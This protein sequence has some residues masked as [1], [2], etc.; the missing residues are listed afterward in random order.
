MSRRTGGPRADTKNV[1]KSVYERLMPG[2]TTQITL[3][4]LRTM[5]GP[6][7]PQLMIETH[8]LTRSIHYSIGR[9]HPTRPTPLLLR[10]AVTQ[11]L[12]LGLSEQERRATSLARGH[13]FQTASS[14]HYVRVS[15][16][17]NAELCSAAGSRLVAAGQAD[18]DQEEEAAVAA[19]A[20][21]A[22]AD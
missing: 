16:A 3:R 1:F 17:K 4:L 5:Q 11:E 7:C 20:A 13:S 18:A 22:A 19:A 15:L 8:T 14:A 6:A 10:C 21:A 2:S 12:E 9:A